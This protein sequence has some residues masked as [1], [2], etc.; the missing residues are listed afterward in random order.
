MNLKICLIHANSLVRYMPIDKGS[1]EIL[2]PLM[3]LTNIREQFSSFTP[4]N[5]TTIQGKHHGWIFSTI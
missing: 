2:S 1:R 4:N 5:N 3:D